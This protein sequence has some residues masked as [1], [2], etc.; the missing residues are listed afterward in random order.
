MFALFWRDKHKRRQS[1]NGQRLSFDVRFSPFATKFVR[2]CNK[3]LRAIT[4][5]EQMQQCEAKLL[6]HLVGA[7]ENRGR[8]CQAERLGGL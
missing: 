1:G 3:S 5:R 8:H 4:G 6:D 7:R 2:R